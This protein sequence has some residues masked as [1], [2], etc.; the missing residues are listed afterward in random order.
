MIISRSVSPSLP[1]LSPFGPVLSTGTFPFGFLAA[2]WDQMCWGMEVFLLSNLFLIAHFSSSLRD[3]TRLR[4]NSLSGFS[5]LLV[6]YLLLLNSESLS[7][8]PAGLLFSLPP[9]FQSQIP[10]SQPHREA[11]YLVSWFLFIFWIALC[12][13]PIRA[14]PH[15]EHQ[16]GCSWSFL[17]RPWVEGWG[18]D[19]GLGMR[20]QVVSPGPQWRKLTGWAWWTVDLLFYFLGNITVGMNLT[21]FKGPLCLKMQKAQF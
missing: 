19:A 9:S 3:F 12:I 11:T 8:N 13:F 21:F 4:G 16:V 2:P 1:I 7:E 10:I 18:K 15:W 5:F 17:G 6:F 14:D 20:R